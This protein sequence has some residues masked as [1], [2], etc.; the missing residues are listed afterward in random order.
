[1]ATEKKGRSLAAAPD[2]EPMTATVVTKDGEAPM[3]SPEGNELIKKAI[4][5]KG[6]TDQEEEAAPKPPPLLGA[7][8][9]QLT[10]AGMPVSDQDVGLIG[11]VTLTP[12]L[13]AG[14][15]L[16]QT[17]TLRVSAVVKSVS[18][19]SARDDWGDDRASVRWQL[20]AEETEVIG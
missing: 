17:I 10:F 15:A 1:M 11:P 9:E 18:G 2:P 13:L 14:L 12:E 16:G 7:R 5:R 4:K 3:G 19:K 6:E 8:G 20:Y